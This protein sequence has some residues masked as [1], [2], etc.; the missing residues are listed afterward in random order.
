MGDDL[1]TI[2]SSTY[3]GE[4]PE[5]LSRY[6]E[7][8]KTQTLQPFEI[9]LC[10]D[11]ELGDKL[12]EIVHTY[13]KLLPLKLVP[14][15]KIGLAKNLQQALL[16]VKT[17]Y[18]ARCD[19][20]DYFESNRFEKQLEFIKSH[21]VDMTSCYAQEWANGEAKY[22][23]TV[24]LSP[25]DNTSLS[26]YFKNPINHHSAFFKTEPVR[27]INYSDGRMEDYR[28]WVACVKQG[29]TILNS[30][31]VL[32]HA[33]AD[34]IE[35]RRFGSDYRAAEFALLRLN[36]SRNLPFSAITS[37]CS[38]AIRYPL[39]FKMLRMGLRIA[40]R[41]SRSKSSNAKLAE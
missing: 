10:L 20:D 4:K 32:V 28:L 23:K 17:S 33:S 13:A 41:T 18:T 11:G 1:Y 30:S 35:K 34:G 29:L 24:P 16:L 31:D 37:I 6:F 14:N 7:T 5:R 36:F 15:P 40:L 21:N 25:L 2:I 22:V 26:L 3:A 19:T 27:S 12:N 38:F 39:R 8:I 9:I